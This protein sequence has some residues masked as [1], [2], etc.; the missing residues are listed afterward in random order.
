MDE[1]RLAYFVAITEEGSV[2]AAAARLHLT[3]PSLSQALRNLE[4]ELG[5]ELF[6]RRGRGLQLS[7]AGHAL[8]DPARQALRA[9]AVARGAVDESSRVASGTLEIAALAT[10]TVDPLAEIVGLFRVT[11]PSVTVAIHEPENAAGVARLVERGSCELGVAHL[12]IPQE[13]LVTIPLSE[14][15]LVFIFPPSSSPPDEPLASA[16]MADVPLV[17]SHPGTS[18][19]ILLE[20]TL[21]AVG[22]VPRIAVQ[23]S[24]REAIVPLVL[25]GAGAALLPAATALEARRRG[26]LVRSTKPRITRQIGL[27]R[28]A[29][30]LSPAAGAFLTEIADARLRPLGLTDPSARQ[31]SGRHSARR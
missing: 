3:Q 16:D 9:M 19:R 30:P 4:R 10:L 26:A 6:H 2:T 27:I 21:A 23:V 17:V 13:T 20:E 1:K 22:A 7:P 18:T 15:E 12:P 31:A 24:A 28:R 14:Q 8:L 5:T 11:H 29:D 25:A